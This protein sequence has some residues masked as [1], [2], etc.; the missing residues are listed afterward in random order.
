MSRLEHYWE[1]YYPQ[2]VVISFWLL[3]L[4]NNFAYVI[5]LSAAHDILSDPN[6][7]STDLPK[8]NNTNRFDCNELSTGAILLADILPGIAIKLIAPLFVHKIKY[9]KRV[10]VVIITNSASFLLVSLTPSNLK[11]LIF[12]GVM[13]ASFSS[14][15]GEITF[16][17]LS[18]LYIRTL[19][20]TGWASGTGAAGL[21]G[22]FGYAALTSLGLS[23]SSTI[24][25]MLFIPVL[26]AF[27]YIALPTVDFSRSRVYA[28]LDN[29][30][31][32][33]D[34]DEAHTG[35]SLA[36]LNNGSLKDKFK[37]LS[38]LLKF[39][40]PLFLVYFAEYFINQGLF[41][42]LYFKNSIIKEH[43]LQYR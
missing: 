37:L 29:D 31:E 27:S 4:T 39:M 15:F 16:L 36:P 1:K 23:P 10:V 25:I 21:I 22:S 34:K 18:T 19:S 43:K 30:S 12:L 32:E 9:W 33:T 3:G 35:N 13:A 5:M 38:P 20:I 41:E 28:E 11:P 7:N 40:I 17:S 26:M 14:S 2:F 24:L 8:H 42:L 6:S